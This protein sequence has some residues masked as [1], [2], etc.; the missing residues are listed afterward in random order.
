MK[1]IRESFLPFALP[2]LNEKE[3]G[4]V[5]DTLNSGWITTGPKVKIFEEKLRSY[6]G[7]AQVVA[8]NSCTA[9]LHLSLV[10]LGIKPGDEVITTPFT[11]AA[12]SNV[13]LH[14][15]AIPVFVD[16]EEETFNIDPKKIE[17]KICKKTKAII[18]MHYGGHPCEMDGII[19]IAKKYNLFIIEDAAHAIG[20][21]YQGKKIGSLETDTACFS[22]YPI[23][24]IT[25]IEGGAIALNNQTVA[26]RIRT[27]SLH[28]INK[29]SYDR[30]LKE[31]S[32]H[33]EIVYPGFKYNMTDIQASLG[34]HQIDKLDRFIAVREEY[35][36]I[37]DEGFRE[38]KEI[39]TPSIKDNVIHARHLYPILLDTDKLSFDRDKFVFELGKRN[40]GC[41]VH[42][43]PLYH[44][45]YYRKHFFF[46]KKD[47]PIT[48][49]VYHGI[50]S[51]PLYPKMTEKDLKDV[52]DAVKD[53]LRDA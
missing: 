18:P 19:S 30:Y 36:R 27:Y 8:V 39:R 14:C 24:N 35:S 41:S 15:G 9:A 1:T 17:D 2:S 26:E 45:P 12:T 28:G 49:K 21:E 11:F 32:W 37:Y 43:I 10:A 33:Y 7:C 6:L 40:I 47:F 25:T 29:G 46:D 51:L 13:V 50:V 38:V 48:E 52:I 16:I 42:F 53:I 4:E 34:I 20:S 3:K 44:H 31:N 22:F 5:I 23:K